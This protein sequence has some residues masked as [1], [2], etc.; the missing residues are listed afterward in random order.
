MQSSLPSAERRLREQTKSFSSRSSRV[1][2]GRAVPFLAADDRI[3]YE[4]VPRIIDLEESRA[5]AGGEAQ[6]VE[7]DCDPAVAPVHM[8]CATRSHVRPRPLTDSI[9]SLYRD[10]GSH[11]DSGLDFGGPAVL[12]PFGPLDR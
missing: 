4:G 10:R 9:S 3:S 2:L 6:L 8:N 12:G 5:E 7:L 11:S 1:L